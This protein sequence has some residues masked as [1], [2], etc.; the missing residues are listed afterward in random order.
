VSRMVTP[1]LERKWRLTT[2]PSGN[3]WNIPLPFEIAPFE[4]KGMIIFLKEFIEAHQTSL[5]PEFSVRSS[6]DMIS[7]K[8]DD[9][10]ILGI[11]FV[12]G[13]PPYDVGIVQNVEI[14]A[15]KSTEKDTYSIII[16]LQRMEGPLIQW[17]K[18]NYLERG[19]R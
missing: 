11:S 9:K 18:T 12:V 17:M 7:S 19:E 4:V 10:E 8:E 5:H 14:L 15:I 6:I 2:K 3:K 13:L 1:S 16:N